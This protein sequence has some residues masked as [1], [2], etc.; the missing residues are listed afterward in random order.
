MFEQLDDPKLA[1]RKSWK[2]RLVEAAI[3]LVVS[4]RYRRSNLRVYR[5]RIKAPLVR[6]PLMVSL[7]SEDRSVRLSKTRGP[8]IGLYVAAESR[9]RRTS[10][11]PL[12]NAVRTSPSP[13]KGIIPT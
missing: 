9:Y 11:W 10:K 13:P 7:D 3:I 12:T 6:A 4:G 5:S 1:G 2:E 8:K